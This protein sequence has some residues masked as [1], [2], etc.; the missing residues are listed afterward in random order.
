MLAEKIKDSTLRLFLLKNLTR[1]RDRGFEWKFNL[2]GI[3]QNIQSVYEPIRAEEPFRKPALFI[4]GEHS[5]YITTADI[6]LIKVLFPE[7]KIVEIPGAGHWVHFDA[8]ESFIKVLL[9]FL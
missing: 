9:D 1:T 3:Y 7:A 8:P 2:Q 4:K 6:P 5:D